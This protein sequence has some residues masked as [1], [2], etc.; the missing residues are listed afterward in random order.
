LDRTQPLLPISFGKTEKRTHDYVRH[1]TTNLFAALEVKTGKVIG[2]CFPRRRATEFLAFM[3]DIARQYEG[4]ELNVV[5]DNLSTRYADEIREWL[6]KNPN[7]TFSFH[8]HRV[9]LD[10]S[11][12][13][14]VRCHHQA[15]HP[16]RNFRITQTTHPGNRALH[17]ELEH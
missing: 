15:G 17:R 9:F 13:D 8:T 7:I 16:L 6:V 11:D 1:G 14:V 10:K 5:L 2:K 12:R 3:K 4:R